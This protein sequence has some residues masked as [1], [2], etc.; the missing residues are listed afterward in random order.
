MIE[1]YI[2]DATLLSSQG[3]LTSKATKYIA[4]EMTNQHRGVQQQKM[5]KIAGCKVIRKPLRSWVI[6]PNLNQYSSS[7][8]SNDGIFGAIPLNPRNYSSTPLDLFIDDI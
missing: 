8:L 7:L 2:L 4:T 5:V 6:S 1:G 3:D